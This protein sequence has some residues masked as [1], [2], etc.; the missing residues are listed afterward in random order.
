MGIVGPDKSRKMEMEELRRTLLSCAGA[1]RRKEEGFFKL[2]GRPVFPPEQNDRLV[3]VTG[4][5]SF[6]G[7]AI[8]NQLLLRGYSVRIL[9][10]NEE[11]LEKVREM[12]ESGEMRGWNG[13]NVAEAVMATSA[14]VESLSEALVG[15]R[16]LIHTAAFVDPAGLSGYS[17]SMAE[18]EV[19]TSKNVVEACARATSVRYCVLTSSLLACVWKDHNAPLNH[20]SPHKI[21]HD[22]WSDES[23]CTAKKL[24]YAL[25]KVK[26]ERAAWEIIAHR[27]NGLKLATI[28]SGLITGPHFCN[29]N[30]TSTIAYLKG[31]KEIYRKGVLATVDVNTLAKAHVAVYE[32]MNNSTAFGRYICF[33]KI[34]SSP[35]DI[36]SLGRETGIDMSSVLDDAPNESQSGGRFELSNSKLNR[37]ISTTFKCNNYH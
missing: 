6:A 33:D 7:I 21:D 11:E 36:E 27:G 14:A 1:N 37:L 18:V 35:E 19:V 24:W 28:C 15:C 5:V 26:A 30:S 3:G 8:V 32:E 29:R 13:G 12:E 31:A 25:G 22:S 34:I 17:K 9:V 10:D 16:G 20:S 23:F 2:S 4:G